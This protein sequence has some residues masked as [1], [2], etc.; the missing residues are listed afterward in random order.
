[1][2]WLSKICSVC[3]PQ[4]IM[5][6]APTRTKSWGMARGHPPGRAPAFFMS[7][8]YSAHIMCHRLLQILARK[9]IR[10][11]SGRARKIKQMFTRWCIVRYKT[12]RQYLLTLQVSIY[13][14]LALQRGML[15]AGVVEWFL[16]SIIDPTLVLLRTMY[17]GLMLGRCWATVVDG[18]PTSGQRWL[19]VP[20][21]LGY[22]G[23]LFCVW[24]DRSDRWRAQTRATVDFLV[25][26]GPRGRAWREVIYNAALRCQK[27]VTA[28]AWIEQLL[29]FGFARENHVNH[30]L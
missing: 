4:K 20:C 8:W 18:G 27:T 15:P 29:P 25:N 19:A 7:A 23:W 12:K 10:D 1:M 14:I 6:V 5:N 13:W 11:Q 17:V 26:D 3:K 28:H 24:H 30:H 22:D 16:G 2:R 9:L 21:L